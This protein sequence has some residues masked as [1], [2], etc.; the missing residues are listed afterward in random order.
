MMIRLSTDLFEPEVPKLKAQNFKS[1]ILEPERNFN[2]L[3]SVLV[4]G[5][6]IWTFLTKNKIKIEKLD[7]ILWSISEVSN[8]S[9]LIF[10]WFENTKQK[11]K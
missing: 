2:Y 3:F 9:Y 7:L 11:K 4:M 10:F 6:K 8:R 1:N 5:V